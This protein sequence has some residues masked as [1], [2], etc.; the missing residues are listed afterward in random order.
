MFFL[1]NLLLG[2]YL[3][4]IRFA[5]LFNTKAWLWVKGRENEFYVLKNK[6]KNDKPY[7]WFHCASMGEF[8]DGRNFIELVR[9]HY[10]NYTILITFFSP[11]G[12]EAR[13]NY[14]HADTIC[15]LPYDFPYKVK[16]FLDIV[17]PRL[18]FFIRADVWLNYLTE[19]KKREIPLFLVSLSMRK[20]SSFLKWPA[21]TMYKKAFKCFTTVFVQDEQT[22]SLAKEKLQLNNVKITGNTR[23]DRVVAARESFKEMPLIEKFKG[24]SFCVITGSILKKDENIVLQVYEQLKHL[25]IKW[26]F[27]PHEIDNNAIATIIKKYPSEMVAY[28]QTE[29]L[30]PEHRGLW[31]DNVGMLAKLYYYVDVAYIG[32]GFNTMGIHNIAEPA[33][34]GKPVAFGPNHRN[35]KEALDIIEIGGATIIDNVDELM[36]FINKLYNNRGELVRIGELNRQYI[37]SQAGGAIKILKLLQEEKV[38]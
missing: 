38:F 17:N 35:Y 16:R 36:A 4:L 26:I 34:F 23:L 29:Y 5:A 6:I 27:V 11:S 12:Y 32:G 19:I 15:Y 1:Y 14:E 28:S 31:I 13:K 22:A 2:F 21:I 3:L 18:V 30:R 25:P 10:P 20:D 9:S 7:V 37:Y 8:E 24:D 33:V